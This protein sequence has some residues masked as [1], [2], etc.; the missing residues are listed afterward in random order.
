MPALRIFPRARASRCAIVGVGTRKAR[1]TSCVDKPPSV[2]RVSAT[3][4]SSPS[5]GWQ[6]VNISFRRSS[7]SESSISGSSS[8]ARES[9]MTALRTSVETRLKRSMARRL[10]TVVSQAP[11]LRGTP[12]I[13]QR[14]NALTSASCSASSA[15]SKSPSWPISAAST[16]PCSSRKVFSICAAAVILTLSWLLRGRSLHDRFFCVHQQHVFHGFILLTDRL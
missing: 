10:A 7:G 16:R 13:S 1:A 5:A 6:Q 12:S 3:C 14:S 11:G 4:A 15:S 9:R 2:C 8:V